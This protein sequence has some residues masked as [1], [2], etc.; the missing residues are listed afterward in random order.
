MN[1]FI[2]MIKLPFAM[3]QLVWSLLLLTLELA[4]ISYHLGRLLV[5]LLMACGRWLRNVYSRWF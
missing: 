2:A 3:L 4:R 5:I 1:L